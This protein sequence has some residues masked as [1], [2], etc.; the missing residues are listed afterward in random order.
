M[1]CYHYYF[2]HNNCK[3]I[4]IPNTNRMTSDY[5]LDTHYLDFDEYILRNSKSKNI[6][7]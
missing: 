6:V 5:I 3:E 1:K 4:Y 7:F 2:F